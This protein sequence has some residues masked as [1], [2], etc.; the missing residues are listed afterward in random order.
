[1]DYKI[2]RD[3]MINLI[4]EAYH[5]FNGE[6]INIY[7]KTSFDLVTNL[8]TDI[9][10]YLAKEIKNKFPNDVI[11]G[12]EFSA[13]QTISQRTWT[14]DPIDGTCNMA[15]GMQLYGVQAA[16][17]ENNEIVFSIIYLPHFNEVIY[18]IKG[19]GCYSNDQRIYV[20]KN[21]TINNAIVSFGDYPHKDTTKIADMQHDVIRNLYSKIAK[22]RMFGAACIDFASVAQAKTDATVVITKNLWDICPGILI[23]KEAGAY[24]TN[25]VGDDYKFGDDGVVACAS[26]E[27]SQLIT[28][29]FILAKGLNLDNYDSLIFDFDGVILDTEKYHYLAWKKAFAKVGYELSEEEYAPLKSMGRV[30]TIKH[31]E[32]K[33][34][35]TF[36]ENLKEELITIKADTFEEGIKNLSED[37]ILP[38]LKDFLESL[39]NKNKKLA[40]ASSSQTCKELLAKYDLDQYFDVVLDGNTK[41]EKKP[42]PVIFLEAK[43]LLGGNNCLVFE[44]SQVGVLAAKNANMDVISIGALNTEDAILRLRSFTNLI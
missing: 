13:T 17:I 44:D 29:N 32:E 41:C 39:K 10:A 18:A 14:I 2:E 40:V 1:M 25:L 11:L 27:L 7:Q 38:G 37:D 12:E 31:L 4:K 34:N 6:N 42:S 23:C 43:R 26:L 9:E 35:T 19:Y 16:L 3:F 21:L 5:K 15:H 33:L 28:K 24:V 30:K 20:N 36:D 22:I 8:D